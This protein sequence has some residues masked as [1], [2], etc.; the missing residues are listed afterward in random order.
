MS[1]HKWT[2]RQAY[3][4]A[5]R[6]RDIANAFSKLA[7]EIDDKLFRLRIAQAGATGISHRAIPD[8]A[9]AKA[10]VQAACDAS[11]SGVIDLA[12][13]VLQHGYFV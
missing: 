4:E 5:K 11:N 13:Q 6:L 10:A 3:A 2:E 9:S 7:W 12:E 1:S 8:I